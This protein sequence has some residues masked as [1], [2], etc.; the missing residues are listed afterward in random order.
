MFATFAFFVPFS[1]PSPILLQS[2]LLNANVESVSLSKSRTNS[3][4]FF[5][6]KIRLPLVPS[7]LQI[8]SWY[9][10]LKFLV[11]CMRAV[12]KPEK[13]KNTQFRTVSK[14]AQKPD[15]AQI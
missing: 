6:Q 1:V 8:C 3:S 4:F 14:S 2:E 7:F 10:Y 12:C 5:L 11:A 15:S 9:M 13:A